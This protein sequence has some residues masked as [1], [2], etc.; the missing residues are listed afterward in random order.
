MK[1]RTRTNPRLNFIDPPFSAGKQALLSK[2]QVRN[3]QAKDV[4]LSEEYKRKF[5]AALH[6]V[7]IPDGST[8]KCAVLLPYEWAEQ[9]APLVKS[10]L[11]GEHHIV[12]DEND[13]TFLADI[14]VTAQGTSAAIN[15]AIDWNGKLVNPGLL[16]HSL[17]IDIGENT[18]D[19]IEIVDGQPSNRS[20]SMPR[21][22][23]FDAVEKICSGLLDRN[24]DCTIQQVNDAIQ[25]GEL[26]LDGKDIPLFKKG[27]D[28]HLSDLS[29]QIAS[30]IGSSLGEDLKTIDDRILTGGG[31]SVLED[32]LPGFLP[33]CRLSD[34]ALFD[35]A[36][37]A[38]KQLMFLGKPRPGVEQVSIDLG[39]GTVEVCRLINSNEI[40]ETV[41]QSIVGEYIKRKKISWD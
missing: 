7:G 9:K 2:G 15:Q 4:I 10:A 12:D 3:S 23:I 17:W 37:G 29:R 40:L 13:I 36:H 27:R 20:F 31:G 19:G 33:R 11:S 25:K 14:Q 24:I 38:L 35:N 22:G 21:L 39:Y 28:A 26:H 30:Q 16:K 32:Y 18:T 41:F 6:A 34:D 5:L 1:I 8:V